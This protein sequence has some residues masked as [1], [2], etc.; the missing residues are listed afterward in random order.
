MQLLCLRNKAYPAV[1]LHN[2]LIK[3]ANDL[4]TKI[5]QIGFKLKLKKKTICNNKL[6]AY[7]TISKPKTSAA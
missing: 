6:F 2:C 7:K 4:H 1:S 5:K 3:H